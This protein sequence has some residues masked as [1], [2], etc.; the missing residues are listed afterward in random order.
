MS[1]YP[2]LNESWFTYE[3]VISHVRMNHCTHTNRSCEWVMTHIWMSQVILI[4]ESC[5]TYEWVMST[6]MWV[7]AHIWM[8]HGKH[9]N[10]SWHTY[11]WVMAQI[12]IS[13]VCVTRMRHFAQIRISTCVT[14]MWQMS[15]CVTPIWHCFAWHECDI[16]YANKSWHTDM[17]KSLHTHRWCGRYQ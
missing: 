13:H 8:S 2:Y 6:Y 5:H 17:N 14:P 3:W 15:T 9:T 12:Q 4:N 11:Q 7:M 10:E 16:S 1:H